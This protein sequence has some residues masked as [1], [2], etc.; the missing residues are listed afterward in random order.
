MA[1]PIPP[2]APVTRATRSSKIDFSIRHTR[3][4]S[5]VEK[6]GRLVDQFNSN[7]DR[8]SSPNAWTGNPEFSPCPFERVNEGREDPCSATSNRVAE[9]DRTTMNVDPLR[10]QSQFLDR[11]HRHDRKRLVDL[12]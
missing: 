1:C 6:V 10:I 8:L 7:S 3:C 12:I 5:C 4:L 9:R 2:T 11:G